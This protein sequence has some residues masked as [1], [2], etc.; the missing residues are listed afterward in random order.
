MLEKLCTVLKLMNAAFVVTCC[1]MVLN[2]AYVVSYRNYF[3]GFNFPKVKI[4]FRP[5]NVDFLVRQTPPFFVSFDLFVSTCTIL[6]GR[7]GYA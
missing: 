3:A 2:L 4:M 1:S 6:N 5:G 7:K